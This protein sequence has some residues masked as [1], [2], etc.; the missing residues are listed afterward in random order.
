MKNYYNAPEAK[1]LVCSSEA[2]VV[3]ASAERMILVGEG[4]GLEWNVADM[5]LAAERNKM[6]V[7]N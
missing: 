7:G 5:K 1:L 2:D 3:T 6:Q 4:A